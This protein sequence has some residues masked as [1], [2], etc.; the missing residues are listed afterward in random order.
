[1]RHDWRLARRRK[2]CDIQPRTLNRTATKTGDHVGTANCPRRELMRTTGT[3][4]PLI[5]VSSTGTFTYD[6]SIVPAVLPAFVQQSGLLTDLDFTWDGVIYDETTAN[7]GELDFDST[8]NLVGA[9]FGDDC[10]PGICSVSSGSGPN[11]FVNSFFNSFVYS[12]AGIEDVF[13][14]TVS[15]AGPLAV[16]EP[17][18]LALLGLG[19]AGLGFS[20]RRTQ[21]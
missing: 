4:G 6:D 9:A 19:M 7:T 10:S 8:G 13:Q 3:S 12:S 20:R 17:A 1:M 21:N 2:Q 11:F 15:L 14:G 18:T 16:P 5:G